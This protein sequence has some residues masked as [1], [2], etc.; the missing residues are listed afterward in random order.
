MGTATAATA[1]RGLARVGREAP[2]KDR[3]SVS[4]LRSGRSKNASASATGRFGA[5]PVE[6]ISFS[7]ADFGN[8]SECTSGINQK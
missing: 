5:C 6:R 4:G 8:R 3:F 2:G 7:L 1:G